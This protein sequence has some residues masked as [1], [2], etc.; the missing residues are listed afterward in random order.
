M[1]FI[2]EFKEFAMRGNVIDMAVGVVIGG[3]FGK[4]VS[5]LVG[6]II[7]PVVGVITGGVNFTDLKLT[8]KEAAEGAPAVT[9]NYGSFIQT[10]VDFLIIA[11]CIFCVIKALNSLKKKPVEEAPVEP[12]TPADIALLTEIRDLLKK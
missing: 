7:M 2:S 9:I 1:S 11:F 4:I 3:A 5:S 10:M 8:L 12:E 6:D